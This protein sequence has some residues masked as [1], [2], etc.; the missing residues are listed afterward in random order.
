MSQNDDL[1]PPTDSGFPIVSIGASAGGIAACSDLLR[2]LPVDTGMGFVIIQH[3]APDSP[4]MLSQIL[5]RVTAMPVAEATQDVE[6]E[7]DHVYVIPP[8]KQMTI[9]DGRLQL[10]PRPSG[11]KQFKSIDIFFKSLAEDGDNRAIGIVLSGL[12]G[13]G[14]QGLKAIKQADG[15]AFTQTQNTAQYGSMPNSAVETGLVDFILSPVEIARQLTSIAQHPYVSRPVPQAFPSIESDSSAEAG[16][17]AVYALLRAATGIDFSQ[18]KRATFERRMARRMA[19]HRLNTVEAYA[20]YLQDHP[21][22]VKALYHD[23]LIT[24]TS[25]FRDPEAFVFLQETVFPSLIEQKGLESSIRIWVAGCSTGQECYSIAIALF[26]Y[27]SEQNLNLSIQ[28][29]GT[30]VSEEAISIARQG[31]YAENQ[32]AGVSPER[33]QRFFT[34]T[35]GRYQISKAVRE[36]CVFARQTLGNDPPFSNIDLISCRNVMIYFAPALQQRV[37]A[38][39]HYSLNAGGQLWLGSSESVGE[40]SKLFAVVDKK[41]KVYSRDTAANQINFDFVTSDYSAL[42]ATAT[43]K[44]EPAAAASSHSNVQRQADQIVLSRYAPVGIVINEQLDILHFRGDTSAYL[45]PA[46][47]E[48]SFSLLKMVQPGLLLELRSAIDEAKT[49]RVASRRERLQI[50]NNPRYIH[51]EVTPIRNPLSKERSYLVLFEEGALIA[52]VAAEPSEP[53]GEPSPPASAEIA[54]FKQ[55]LAAARQE[56]LDTQAYLQA[57]IE[58][59][60]ATNQQLTTANEEI[61]SSNEELQSTNEEL[62]TAKEEIQAANEELTTTNEELQSRNADARSTNDDLLNLLNNVNIPIVMLSDDLRIRRFTPTAQRLFNLIPTDVGRPVSDI[63][64]DIDIDNLESLISEVIGTLDTQDLEVQDNEGHWYRLRIRPY[65]TADNQIDGAV[66]A[67]VDID[68]MKRTLQ[69][70]EMSRLYAERIVETVRSPLVVLTADLQVKTAN[71]AFYETFQVS[72]SETEGRELFELG[73]G[74]WDIPV[75][76]AVLETL[77]ADS[78][79]VQDFEIDHEFDQIG[80]KIMLL[81]AREIEQPPAERLILLSIEDITK[82]KRAEAQRMQ[83][84][85]ERTARVEAESANASKDEFLSVLSHELRTPLSAII[86]WISILLSRT[87]PDP[88]LLHRALTS[89]ERSARTQTRIIEDLLQVSRIIQGQ[90]ELQRQ[91]VNLSDLVKA[92]VESMLPTA[93]KA[94]I[95]LI[96]MLDEPPDYFYFDPDRLQQVFSNALANAIK[97]TPRDGQIT[98]RLTYSVDQAQVQITDTG[99]GI[100]AD[101]LPHVFDRFRQANSSSAR[102]YGGLGIGLTIVKT[103]VEAHNGTVRISS[104]GIGMG[105]TLTVVLP[106]TAAIAPVQTAVPLP[107]GDDL[108]SG[109]RILIVEDDA[110]NREILTIVLEEQAATVIP[111]SSVAAAIEQLTDEETPDLLISDINLPGRDGFELIDWVRS[112]AP[113]QGGDLPAIALTGYAG[114]EHTESTLKAGFQAHLVKPINTDEL[115]VT[116]VNLV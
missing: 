96:A 101:F 41:H 91:A 6:V 53:G 58:E 68:A 75:L 61:L 114:S 26:E 50:E 94:G 14:A 103:F 106:L 35:E 111:A 43:A 27:L 93:E 36:L 32:V 81:N 49:Q 12:D 73:N 60:D 92:V 16:L 37:L 62:Q 23:V 102:E 95:Q 79:Q 20:E 59:H 52:S 112:R 11:P 18:Y 34:Q 66:I 72:L 82:R 44:G 10:A 98:T 80:R 39:F 77:L 99:R 29:F 97:F 55:E 86:G 70:L 5:G 104:P 85:Q 45:R 116:I 109:L 74:Q 100:D 69:Q 22:E 67:L 88:T 40:T 65:R 46:P 71:Y 84:T 28:I 7:P 108:L 30:D 1:Q 8:N 31:I 2:A 15:I 64:I 90:M 4:S 113:E 25:F 51:I 110:D 19:L 107:P 48:P 89:I 105:T 3:L 9:A 54:R 56:L 115:M 78:L 87:E 33:L 42:T 24:V 13:D 76:R 21:A 57:T 83:L 17:S 47:G 38:V 63:R